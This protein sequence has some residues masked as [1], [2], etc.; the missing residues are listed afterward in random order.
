[1]QFGYKMN[2]Y[3]FLIAKI[4]SLDNSTTISPRI[5]YNLFTK[6]FNRTVVCQPKNVDSYKVV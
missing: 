4:Y 3:T 5:Y 2:F 6:N 1:M